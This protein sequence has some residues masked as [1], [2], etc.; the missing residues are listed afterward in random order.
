MFIR[1]VLYSGWLRCHGLCHKDA[2]EFF[3]HPYGLLR[4]SDKQFKL[5]S[6]PLIFFQSFW[7]ILNML[8]SLSNIQPSFPN[9]RPSFSNILRDFWSLKPKSKAWRSVWKAWSSVLMIQPHV[10]VITLS[11]LSQAA[12]LV[13][14]CREAYCQ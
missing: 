6:K 11:M 4:N 2:G 3:K 5:S 14:V 9:T 10:C 13:P 12:R 1:S 8:P 7:K